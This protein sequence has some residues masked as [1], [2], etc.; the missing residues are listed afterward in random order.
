MIPKVKFQRELKLISFLTLKSHAQLWLLAMRWGSKFPFGNIL[1]ESSLQASL[2]Q[3]LI[4]Y[5]PS[6]HSTKLN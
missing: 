5:A 2:I 3:K 6:F 1:D 4:L